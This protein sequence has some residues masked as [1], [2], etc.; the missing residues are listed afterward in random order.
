MTAKR[1]GFTMLDKG[2][3]GVELMG[4]T[5]QLRKKADHLV[6]VCCGQELTGM[7]SF[8]LGYLLHHS[9]EG[10]AVY[11]RDLER[12][13]HITRSTASGIL[14]LMEQNGLIT[15]EKDVAEDAR[16]KRIVP[17]PRGVELQGKVMQVLDGL[18]EKLNGAL[19]QEEQ[20]T[21]L[22]LM[23]KLW[24]ALDSVDSPADLPGGGA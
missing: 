8:I 14:R 3:L 7:Q 24:A 15:R 20:K 4:F 5:N 22:R 17:T 12:H 23:N 21:Y 2:S 1:E 18:Q 11:Q 13:F 6:C 10:R 16:L 9:G 19:T